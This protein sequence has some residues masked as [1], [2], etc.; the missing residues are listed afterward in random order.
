MTEE[1]VRAAEVEVAAQLKVLDDLAAT[2]IQEAK[3]YLPDA[4]RDLVGAEISRSPAVVERIGLDGLKVVKA[5]V[6]ALLD[7][8]PGIVDSVVPPVEKWWHRGEIPKEN[9]SSDHTVLHRG[10]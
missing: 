7:K 3:T 4:I 9:Y 2:Y 8:L 10:G 1:Q 5:E 6:K